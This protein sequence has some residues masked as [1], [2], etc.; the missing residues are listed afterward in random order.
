[1]LISIWGNSFLVSVI[2]SLLFLLALICSNKLDLISVILDLIFCQDGRLGSTI[3][4]GSVLA[5]VGL[6]NLIV[7]ELTS[8][9]L[10]ISWL[11]KLD[12]SISLPFWLHFILVSEVSTVCWFR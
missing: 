2:T 9:L 1:M 8:I 3:S 4:D 12:V 5:T 7:L 10:L 11:D 6:F